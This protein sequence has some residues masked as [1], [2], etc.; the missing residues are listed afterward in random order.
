MNHKVFLIAT[1]M[2]ALII[3]KQARAYDFSSVAPSGQTLYYN[4]VNGKAKVV[5]GPYTPAY[6]GLV[7]ALTIPSSVTYNGNIYR[8][9]SIDD[10]AFKRC[11]RLI[12]V[13]IPN[14]VTKIGAG[15]FVD[16]RGL[17]TINIPDSVTYIGDGAFSWCDNLTTVDF[18]AINCTYMGPGIPGFVF[19]DSPHITTLNIGEN[20]TNIPDYAFCG[21]TSLSTVIIPNSVTNIGKYA[22]YGCNKLTTVSISQNVTWINI[23]TFSGCRLTSV[24]IPDNVT[25]IDDH[26]FEYCTHLT[27]IISR[28]TVRPGLGYYVFGRND[29]FSHVPQDIPLYVPCGAE[30]SYANSAWSRFSNIFCFI[31]T[32]FTVTVNAGTGGSAEGG[33]DAVFGE[34][35]TIRAVADDGYRF[36][37]WNDGD[38]NT[39]RTVIVTSDSTFNAYFE[40][41]TQG[42][43]NVDKDKITVYPNPTNGKV[44]IDADDVIRMDV[45]N[46]NGKLVKTAF[47]ESVIDISTLPSGVYMLKVETAQSKYVCR[48]IRR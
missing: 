3:P 35:V 43:F 40:S 39:K 22:F 2:M 10:G 6:T 1:I 14:S 11:W 29:E 18:N 21:C 33:G 41:T 9:T 25:Y 23:Y 28:A 44:I 13:S 34:Y 5:Y 46:I 38:T 27:S 8:V 26:A 15:A 37:R 7:G 36:L 20:V 32:V 31:D 19:Q 16:C 47:K 4:I 30:N 12:S 17:T 42:I 45:Y 48:V 24:T